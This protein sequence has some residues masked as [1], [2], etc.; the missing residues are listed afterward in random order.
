MS[1][2]NI[3]AWAIRNPVPPIVLFLF[4][5][6]AGLVS[7]NRMDVNNNPDIDFPIVW[8][9]ISQPGA[10]P[11]ELE[12]QITQKVESAVRSLQGIDEINSTVT[13]GSSRRRS[14]SSRSARRSIARSR[15][16]AARSSRSAA[17]CPTAS[18]SRRSAA[19]IRPATTTS[20]ASPRRHRHDRRAAQLVYRQHVAKEPALDRGHVG[21]Q[22]QRRRQ[23][24]DPR[25]RSRQAPVVGLTASQVNQ[26][27]R[28]VNMNAAGGRAEISG[29]EQS[30]RVIGN[31]KDAYTLGQTQISTGGGRTVRL[32]DIANV[33]DSYA[34][35][36]SMRQV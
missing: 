32:A 29:F 30:V 36:R 28:A 27:L 24:R 8:I 10:A 35:Q 4:L 6:V 22:P 16:C 17:I 15:T 2:R 34:E 3:S 12:T 14:S 7:F 13:E 25:P 21:G 23:S 31:A 1:F 33:Q 18:S 19:S 11:S 26:Q 5:T 20:P 9:A